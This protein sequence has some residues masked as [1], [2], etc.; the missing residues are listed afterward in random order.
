[1]KKILIWLLA[2]FSLTSISLAYDE[3][4]YINYWTSTLGWNYKEVVF[5][6]SFTEIP[7]VNV[8]I[9]ECSWFDNQGKS[10]I[11][12]VWTSRISVDWFFID[13]YDNATTNDVCVSW[14]AYD[15]FSHVVS[16]ITNIE[17]EKDSFLTI[18]ELYNFYQLELTILLLITIIVIL[19]KLTFW[20]KKKD[21]FI[22]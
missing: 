6:W 9:S 11:G 4:W 18:P 1:M 17:S 2:F 21:K 15:S 19:K 20:V 13:F 3:W 10:S 8:T 16:N 22:L 5:S 14:F 12:Y 7:K